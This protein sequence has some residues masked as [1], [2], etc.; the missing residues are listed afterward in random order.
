MDI[1][2]QRDLIYKRRVV[3]V[4]FAPEKILRYAVRAFPTYLHCSVAVGEDCTLM[5]VNSDRWAEK[6]DHF[7]P[8]SSQ[9]KD[10][11]PGLRKTRVRKSHEQNAYS[12]Y[13]KD[14]S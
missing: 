8:R 2:L 14:R 5:F 13:N 7:C 6:L 10:F 12:D 11:F 4:V 9:R 1:R 3:C